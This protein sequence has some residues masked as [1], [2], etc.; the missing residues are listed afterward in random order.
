MEMQRRK[1]QG[2]SWRPGVLE[3]AKALAK[4]DGRSLSDYVNR[5]VMQDQH[6]LAAQQRQEVANAGADDVGAR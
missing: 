6:K 5:L 3:L 4:A 2:I 1:T